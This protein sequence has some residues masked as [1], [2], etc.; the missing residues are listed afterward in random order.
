MAA[1]SRNVYIDK[2]NGIVNKNNNT[3]HKT[4]KMKSSDVKD[5]LL[6]ILIKKFMMKILNSKLVIM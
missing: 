3:C 6:L 5:Y 1:V 2:L 4:I